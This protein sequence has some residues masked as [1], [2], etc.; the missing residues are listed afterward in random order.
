[1]TFIITNAKELENLINDRKYVDNLTIYNYFYN[2]RSNE[3]MEKM[4]YCLTDLKFLTIYDSYD[5]P[6]DLPKFPNLKCYNFVKNVPDGGYNL[7]RI[8]A[9]MQGLAYAV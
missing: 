7:L 2:L 4:L 6:L 3:N 9:G 1:M 8:M 5:K